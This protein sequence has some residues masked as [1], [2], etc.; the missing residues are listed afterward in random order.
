[1]VIDPTL[2]Q[3]L[4]GENYVFVGSKAELR[5]LVLGKASKLINT[6]RT[7]SAKFEQ[8]WGAET[9]VRRFD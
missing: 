3:V 2:G 1:V 8:M 5:D 9:Y 6:S 7:P 4:D